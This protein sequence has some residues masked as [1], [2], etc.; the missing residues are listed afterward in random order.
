MQKYIINS[1][2]L[3]YTQT[4][5]QV[6]NYVL[7]RYNDKLIISELLHELRKLC[8]ENILFFDSPNYGLTE[9]GNYILNDTKYFYARQIVEYLR[10][11]VL[12]NR[13]TKLASREI[14]EEQQKLRDYLV[15]NKLKRC[16]LCC[17]RLPLCLLETAHL[18]PRCLIKPDERM[19]TNL[20]EFMC[21]YCHTLY[22]SGLLGVDSGG[23]LVVSNKLSVGG[24]DINYRP[25]I[26]INSFTSNNA[27][28][29]AK[30][31]R[32]IFIS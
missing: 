12:R 10:K 28:F 30:H 24:Y 27:S 2:I 14:R 17:K 20:V 8:R 26:L 5:N 13:S 15:A 9:K 4:V 31:L 19:D 23:L 32:T 3:K 22:D 25:G 21:R 18:V 7:T 6:Y 1:F 16:I 11:C 29:F